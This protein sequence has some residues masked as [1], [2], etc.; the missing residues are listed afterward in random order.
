MNLHDELVLIVLR[1]QH[2]YRVG[3]FNQYD[4]C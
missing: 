3:I 4:N 2:N 1:G